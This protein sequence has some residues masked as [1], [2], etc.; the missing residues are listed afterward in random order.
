MYIY[1]YYLIRIFNFIKEIFKICFICLK[2]PAGCVYCAIMTTVFLFLFITS[3][4]SVSIS[5]LFVAKSGLGL[6]VR[7]F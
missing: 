5:L 7:E 6:N 2:S 4:T 1:I 3:M